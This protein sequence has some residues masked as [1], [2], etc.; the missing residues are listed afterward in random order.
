M[1]L[2]CCDAMNIGIGIGLPAGGGGGGGYVDPVSDFLFNY[3]LDGN[4]SALT[5]ISSPP[6]IA[7][8]AL[9]DQEASE[10]NGTSQYYATTVDSALVAI[11]TSASTF[12]CWVRTTDTT[13]QVIMGNGGATDASTFR[14]RLNSSGQIQFNTN[15]SF[16]T[17]S[18]S[19]N[20]GSWVH[21]A[22]TCAGSGANVMFYINAVQDATVTPAPVYNWGDSG[23]I[24]I[25]ARETGLQRFTGDIDD[26]RFYDRV[27]TP[28]E[29]TALFNNK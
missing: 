9:P 15:G 22:V 5:P 11:G 7:G 10:F 2:F 12:S 1:S 29:I 26:V 17:S 14:Y 6:I 16:K 19:A 13:N 25:G 21:V 23:A 4:D 20:S 24:G 18:G 3:R 27:L 28:A 8:L